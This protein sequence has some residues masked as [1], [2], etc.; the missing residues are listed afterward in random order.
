MALP[1][2]LEKLHRALA[3]LAAGD[4]PLANRLQAAWSGPIGELW[5][6]MYLP[7]DL[8]DQFKQLWA[9]YAAPSDD[10]FSTTLRQLTPDEQRSAVEAVV[11]LAMATAAADALDVAPAT[12]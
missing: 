3:V 10:P 9:D 6:G 11:S 12:P 2:A 1:N 7:R 5:T 8:N 4:Q